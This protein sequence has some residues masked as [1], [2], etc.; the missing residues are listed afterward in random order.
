[1]LLQQVLVQ[2]LQGATREREQLKGLNEEE[3]GHYFA[4][5]KKLAWIFMI[6]V[7]VICKSDS[8]MCAYPISLCNVNFGSGLNHDRMVAS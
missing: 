3:K 6:P 4:E 2:C 1:M 7:S 8:T 5:N